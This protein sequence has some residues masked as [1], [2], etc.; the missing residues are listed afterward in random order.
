MKRALISGVT[1]VQLMVEAELDSIRER[2]SGVLR[3]AGQN[4]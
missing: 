3:P 2:Q 4:A 1:V